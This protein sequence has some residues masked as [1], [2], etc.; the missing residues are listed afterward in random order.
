MAKR[1][2]K[3]SAAFSTSSGKYFVGD[4][5]KLLRTGALKRYEGKVQLI[6]TS[7]PFPLNLKK[8]YGNLTGDSYLKW[9]TELAPLLTKLLKPTGSV[10]IEI[11]NAWES[12]RPVQ[13]LLPLKALIGF[14]ESKGS[15]LRLCQEFICYNPSRLP[16]PAAWVTTRR[17]RAV[18]SYTHIWWMAKNNFPKANN[19]R[20]LRPYSKK[21][22]A[23]LKTGK[24]NSGERPSHHWISETAFLKDC[25]G[26]ISHNLLEM[27]PLDPDREVRLPNAFSFS[28]TSS[29]DYFS[30]ECKK[31]KITPHP[32][33]MPMGLAAFFVQFLTTSGD[34]VF[35]PFGGTNTTGYVAERL[36]RKWLT[37][38]ISRSYLSQ[39]KLR[40][41]DPALK[42][43]KKK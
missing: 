33:R 4:V 22:Q 30:R 20:V 31:R 23:L 11:G 32:A 17:I 5:V 27:D 25:G 6:V 35:D 14:L 19:R 42:K 29:N 28:N 2:A 26:S 36:R 40:F 18:D 10:V 1:R 21:M 7:P 43:R 15:N 38:E 37:T 8:S 41:T 24:F 39:A 3:L 34:L 9:F 13:S 12:S 16:S